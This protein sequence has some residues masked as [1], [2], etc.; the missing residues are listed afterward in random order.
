MSRARLNVMR[1]GLGNRANYAVR[2]ALTLALDEGDRLKA[3]VIAARTGIPHR[4]LPQVLAL[5]VKAGWVGSA[6]GPDGGY[7]LRYRPEDI[8]VRAIVEAVE[9]P[10]YSEECV[11]RGGPCDGTCAVHPHWNA[12]QTALLER[13]DETSFADLCLGYT[14]QMEPAAAMTQS[15]KT[16]VDS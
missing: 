6:A 13:L 3:R 11:L 16:D 14:K 8:S 1:L 12:A 4:Y 2:A 15:T 7:F 10:L 5:L 9:G